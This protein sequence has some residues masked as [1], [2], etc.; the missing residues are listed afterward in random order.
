MVDADALLRR[1]RGNSTGGSNPPSSALSWSEPA[2][3]RVQ[4]L[5]PFCVNPELLPTDRTMRNSEVR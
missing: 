5:V 4:T 3:C 2:G 1:C